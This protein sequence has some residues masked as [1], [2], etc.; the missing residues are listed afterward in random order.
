LSAKKLL[1]G[2]SAQ[3]DDELRA[4]LRALSQTLYHPVG[5]CAL[6][7]DPSSVVDPELRVR[8]V[9]GLRVVDAS[10][11]PQLPRGH[12]NWPVVMVAERA[13]ELIAG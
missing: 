13:A 6:G 4:H 5:T 12:T 8:G 3:T 7:V 11:I 2:A 9:D 1:P 10:V